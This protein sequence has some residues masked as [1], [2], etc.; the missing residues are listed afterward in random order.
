[1][2][3]R[4]FGWIRFPA[5]AVGM[6]SDIAAEMDLNEEVLLCDDGIAYV[7]YGQ[8]DGGRNYSLER[9]LNRIGCPFDAEAEAGIEFPAELVVNRPAEDIRFT[10]NTDSSA[11]MV[12]IERIRR[13][14]AD[15]D[16]AGAADRVKALLDEVCPAYPTLAQATAA[17]VREAVAKRK[18]EGQDIRAIVEATAKCFE[19][20]A[21]DNFAREVGLPGL[22]E[23]NA[24]EVEA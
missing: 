9:E 13:A 21:D 18:A 5:L 4:V 12:S 6:E 24:T 23:S 1:M 17:W 7:A 14:M 22:P 15:G 16:P 11:P 10:V 8:T 2:A 19:S 3:E 20:E